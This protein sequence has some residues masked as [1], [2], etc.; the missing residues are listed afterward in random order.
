M[1]RGDY[2]NIKAILP[3][4][5]KH[6]PDVLTGVGVCTAVCNMMEYIK[7]SPEELEK[8][9]YESLQKNMKKRGSVI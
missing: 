5:S 6:I 8:E 9:L 3:D 4:L 2:M 7:K 1:E